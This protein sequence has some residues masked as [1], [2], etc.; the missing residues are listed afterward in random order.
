[1]PIDAPLMCSLI[2]AGGHAGVVADA[3]WQN[4]PLTQIAIHDDNTALVGRTFLGLLPITSPIHPKEL[5]DS[6]HVAIGSNRIRKVWTERIIET[7][8][9]LLTVKHPK[10]AISPMAV[11]EGGCFIAALSVVSVNAR[12]GKSVIVNHGAIVDHDCQIGDYSHIAPHATLGG[13]VHIGQNTL[14][15]AGAVVL[16]QCRVGRDVVI[17]AGSVV[18]SNIPDGVVAKGVPARWDLS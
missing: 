9:K 10:A 8:H 13:G 5:H 1:M 7:N 2:G 17:G 12:L 3:L 4:N 18:I 6:C 15:G 16:P 14:V 11:I